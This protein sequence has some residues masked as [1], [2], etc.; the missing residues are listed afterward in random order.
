MAKEQ[1]T[2][3]IPENLLR[4]IEKLAN[5]ELRSKANMIEYILTDWMRN[6]HDKCLE[7]YDEI[8]DRYV[9]DEDESIRSQQRA[10][11]LRNKVASKPQ[12]PEPQIDD[13]DFF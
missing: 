6:N 13:D 5:D 1:L 2:I 7:N 4:A 11:L 10:K 3:H 8:L 9:S 12:M